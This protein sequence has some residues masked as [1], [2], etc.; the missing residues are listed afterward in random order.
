MWRCLLR[1]LYPVRRP[2]A[3]PDCVLLKDSSVVLAAVRGPEVN[4]WACLWVL[5]RPYR[6]I[7]CCLSSQHWILPFILYL[8]T[9]RAGSGP[10]KWW[11]GPPLQVHLQFHFHI[12]WNILGPINERGLCQFAWDQ[13]ASPPPTYVCTRA[14]THTHT[15]TAHYRFRICTKNTSICVYSMPWQFSLHF[16]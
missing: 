2:V 12:L 11:M 8:E 16:S 4:S 10:T 7:K 15:H 9:P 3:A 6:S 1:V 5:G 13:H 14:H